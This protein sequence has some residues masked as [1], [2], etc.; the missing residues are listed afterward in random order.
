MEE[1]KDLCISGLRTDGAHHKQWFLEEILKKLGF[2][3]KKISKELI[4][5]EVSN[6]GED[7]N[8]Y[9][10]YYSNDNYLWEDGIP[11]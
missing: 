4:K 8:E 1:I 7:P 11:P 3:L 10:A 9:K 5:E 2:N 6:E